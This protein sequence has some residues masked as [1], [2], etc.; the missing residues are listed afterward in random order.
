MFVLGCVLIDIH[1]CIP[2]FFTFLVNMWSWWRSRCNLSTRVFK[3]IERCSI[4]S[5]LIF[6]FYFCFWSEAIIL[7]I[8]SHV[9]KWSNIFFVLYFTMCWTDMSEAFFGH[10]S[11]ISA[12]YIACR[13][14]FINV[15]FSRRFAFHIRSWVSVSSVIFLINRI[16]HFV[17]IFL[18]L[19]LVYYFVYTH[20]IAQWSF[21]RQCI[22]Y[23]QYI[24]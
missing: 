3:F 18:L 14:T 4:K 16:F 24:K 6:C 12:L 15:F 23:M 20:D 11:L 10:L 19:S 2:L 8:I 5:F 17:I 13:W 1:Q 7:Y 21:I 9:T 22:T